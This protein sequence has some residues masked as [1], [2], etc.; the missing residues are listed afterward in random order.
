MIRLTCEQCGHKISVQ[1]KYAG[2]QI[3]CAECRTVLVVPAFSA[4]IRFQC[5]NCGRKIRASGIHA[6]KKVKCPT[7][8]FILTVPAQTTELPDRPGVVRFT[9]SSCNRSI[10]ETESSRGKLI[11]CPHCN[12]YV[13]VPSPESSTQKTDISIQT[14]Q[15]NDES[16]E[17]Y[18]QLQIGSIKE[19]KQ[20][21]NVVTTRKLPWILDIF[22]FP[23]SMSGLSVLAIIVLTRFFF[24]VT[25]LFLHEAA[26]QFLPCIAFFGLMVPIGILARIVI[27]MYL[28]WYFCECIRGS[29][30]GGVRAVET[31]GYNPGLWEMFGY[32]FR[33]V[34][35][36][37]LYQFPA[38]I[39]L[40]LTKR[41]DAIFW[42]LFVFGT[43][44]L[45]M[46]FIGISIY[47]TLR[48]L[49]PV[50]VVG[51]IFSTFLPY[52]AMILT[53]VATGI[54]I[55]TKVTDPYGSLLSFFIT[56]LVGVYLLMVV[57]H[58]LGWFYHRYEEKLNWDV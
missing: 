55:V 41:A 28:C 46:S 18:E 47:E 45:P 17:H 49:N 39:Y 1:D 3:K 43:I 54:V 31:K 35:C 30:A 4:P 33:I 52:F 36:I 22:L 8:K 26:Q 37:V 57:A 50:L 24:R 9:C 13:A 5:Q 53:F 27:Y 20:P 21:P 29:A 12:A 19:F 15:E 44:F 56:W 6:G 34:L 25:V 7:C 51:S 40:N 48:G 32:T 2:K 58:L 16:E 11:P 14:E 38:I 10:E 42:S 23:T